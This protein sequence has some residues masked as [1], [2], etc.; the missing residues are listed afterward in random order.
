MSS[1]ILTIKSAATAELIEKK[2]RFIA[3]VAPTPD[4]ESAQEFIKSIKTKHHDATHN[5]Y[6]FQV[7]GESRMQRSSDDGEPAG[8]AGRPILEVIKNSGLQDVTV[9]VTRY[10]GGILLGTGGLVRAYSKSAQL[11]LEA[12][13]IVELT[14]GLVLS[15]TLDYSLWNKVENYLKKQNVKLREPLFLEKITV[16]VVCPQDNIKH[17]IQD[18]TE[19]G[20]DQ[21]SIMELPEKDYISREIEK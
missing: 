20:N 12:A 10:F 17:L 19:I 13:G 15:L 18:L 21:I 3:Y 5:C 7:G 9:V 1:N 8:T 14:P 2:S 16:L 4:I 6:A 11:G